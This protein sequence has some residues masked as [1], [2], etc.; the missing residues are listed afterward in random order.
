MSNLL[1]PWLGPEGFGEA[2]GA[3]VF[4][5]SVGYSPGEAP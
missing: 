1:R 5:K 4:G 3:S 2:I